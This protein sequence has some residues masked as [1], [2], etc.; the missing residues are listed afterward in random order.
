MQRLA[1]GCAV[2]AL[3]VNDV[4]ENRD[5]LGKM[6]AD[7][8]AQVEMVE[9]G[10]QALE[11]M[12]SFQPDIVFLDIRMPG[13]DGI[14]T[15]RRLREKP[16]WGKVKVVAIS[17]SVLEHE[18]RAFL[19]AGFDDF[20]DKPFRFEGVCEKLARQLGVVFEYEE[21]Q[22]EGTDWQGLVLP[23]ELV[24]RLHSAAELYS[25]TDIE[26]HLG[27]L[28]GLGEGHQRLAA[29]L[30]DLNQRQDMEAILR[31]LDQLGQG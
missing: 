19:G 29:H 16:S 28:E 2:K 3:V 31:L 4:A 1:P 5:I 6:L 24:S 7:L 11:R 20:L 30:R 8:G 17:A 18:R 26:D 10:P 27:E 25:V 14:Q 23:Q 22:E 12:D 15:L 21:E 9:S 13:M